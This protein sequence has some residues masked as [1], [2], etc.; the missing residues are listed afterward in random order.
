[1][2]NG[3]PN[4]AN[5]IRPPNNLDYEK[6]Y[7]NTDPIYIQEDSNS[8][9]NY[10]IDNGNLYATYVGNGD[11][12]CFKFNLLKDTTLIGT[13]EKILPAGT[14]ITL[15]PKSSIKGNFIVKEEALIDPNADIGKTTVGVANKL[16]GFIQKTYN[17]TNNNVIGGGKVTKKTKLKTRKMKRRQSKTRKSKRRHRQVKKSWSKSKRN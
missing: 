13:P 15:T 4:Y 14:I 11:N 7:N 17:N 10:Y 6:H 5:E 8:I 1:M 9:S 12:G 2:N 16:F 3:D